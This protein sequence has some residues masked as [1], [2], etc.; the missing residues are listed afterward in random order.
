MPSH[1]SRPCAKVGCPNLVRPP[2][3]YCP[4]HKAHEAQ[5]DKQYDQYYDRHIRDQRSKDFYNSP[6]WAAAR[7]M[8]LIRDKYLCQVCLREKRI[9]HTMTVHHIIPIREAWE[10]RLDLDNMEATCP[11]CH[12]AER[13]RG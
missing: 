13:R 6:E 11:A 4:Q 3:R 7:L 12:N 10:R 2:E 5:R 8:V 9:T 1:S